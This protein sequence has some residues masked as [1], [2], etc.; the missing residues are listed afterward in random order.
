MSRRIFITSKASQDI[1][2]AF[3]YI[4][5]NNNEVALHFFDAAR[6]TIAQLAMTPGKGSIFEID[7]P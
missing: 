2:L 3:A 6:K 5:Q 7:N 4:A 1:D